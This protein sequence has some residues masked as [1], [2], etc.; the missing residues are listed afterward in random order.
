MTDYES[1]S[2]DGVQPD[3]IEVSRA[4]WERVQAQLAQAREALEAVS[5]WDRT[6][7]MM[8]DMETDAVFKR[9]HAALAALDAEEVK[10]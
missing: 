2:I 7:G 10:A 8:S 9:V 6:G 1:D 4:E 3:M 5:E